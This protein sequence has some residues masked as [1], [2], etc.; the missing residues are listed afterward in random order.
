MDKQQSN[1]ELWTEFPYAGEEQ[2]PRNGVE[3]S[4]GS[5]RTHYIKKNEDGDFET[6]SGT[7]INWPIRHPNTINWNQQLRVVQRVN[8]NLTEREITIVKFWGAGPPSKQWLP[9]VDRLID[10]YAVPAPRAARI[11]G[12]F[13]AGLND[14]MIVTWHFKY[15][16]LVARPNQLDQNLATVI[17]T[18]RH[19][20]YPSGHA[21]LSG[22]AATILSYFF[23]AQRQRLYALAEEAAMSRLYAGIHFPVDNQQGLRLG[24][25]IGLIAVRELQKDRNADGS[26]V[27][28][29]YREYRDAEL[30]PPPYELALPFDYDNSC[31][32]LVVDTDDG[33]IDTNPG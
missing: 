10:I 25:Q 22:A 5:W 1:Y 23:P 4:A 24:R 33:S 20:S 16:W 6:L 8:R 12:A 9:I 21:T 15:K 27:D 30:M 11:L 26:I 17:C 3:P 32:S 19:P 18:P 14:A 7:P 2:P 28:T 31:D 29:P 13:F